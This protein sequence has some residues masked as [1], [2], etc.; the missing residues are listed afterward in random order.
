[1][2]NIVPQYDLS[3]ITDPQQFIRYCSQVVGQIVSGINGQLDFTNLDTQTVQVTF[4]KANANT[5]IPHQLNK[6]GVNYIVV[7]KSAAADILRGSGDSSGQIVLVATNPTDV[8]L[9]L[10]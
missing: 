2:S 1:M 4:Q 8:T 9:V 7:S 3:N 5:P 6:T 10:F